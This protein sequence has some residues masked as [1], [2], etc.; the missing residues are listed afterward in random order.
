MH[1]IKVI[2]NFFINKHKCVAFF[3]NCLKK[4]TNTST[5]SENTLKQFTIEKKIY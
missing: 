2:C 3:F 4:N 5:L 1:T